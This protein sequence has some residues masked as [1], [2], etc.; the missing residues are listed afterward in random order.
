MAPPLPEPDKTRGGNVGQS[1]SDSLMA[2]AP[3]CGGTD[4]RFSEVFDVT[5]SDSGDDDWFD[6]LVDVDTPLFIDPFLI[7]EEKEG[8]WTNAHAHLIDF[9]DVV[10]TMIGEARGN[11]R[12]LAWKQAANLLLFPEPAEFRFGVAEGSPF[13]AGSSRGLQT[14]MLDGIKAATNAGMFHIAHMETIALFQGG[15]GPDRIG[16]AVSN[17]LKSR[18]IEYTQRICARHQI[19]T[20]RVPVPNATWSAED[21]RWVDGHRELPTS[22]LGEFVEVMSRSSNFP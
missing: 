18:F 4:V 20:K 14:D 10:F 19:P 6:V 12:H 15:M 17:I 7:W 21:R 8:F 22:C 16:D 3:T 2:T 9:F 1:P 5:K 13:G 11:T